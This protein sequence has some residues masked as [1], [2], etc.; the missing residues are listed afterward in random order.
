MHD[1][2]SDGAAVDI[3][4]LDNV[5]A[6]GTVSAELDD[7]RVTAVST[8]DGAAVLFSEGSDVTSDGTAVDVVSLENVVADGTVSAQAR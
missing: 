1:V 8:V 7:T 2:T 3:V 5:V 4:S 6:D